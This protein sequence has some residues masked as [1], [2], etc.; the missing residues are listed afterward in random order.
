[1]HDRVRHCL[2][3]VALLL[4]SALIVAQSGP[5]RYVYDEL[6][7]LITVIDQNGDAA[8]YQYDAVGNL[9]S[10]TRTSAGSVAIFE[11][12]PNAGPVGSS[13][14]LYGIGFSATPTQ[15]T[16]TINGTG[17][18]VTSASTTSLVVTVPS[19]T[20]SG[21]IAVTS[22]NGSDTS[23]DSFTVTVS[24]APTISSFTPSSGVA[25][26]SISI[27]GTN[28]EIVAPANVTRFNSSFTTPSAATTT[29][30]TA[31]VP[32]NTGSGR[33]EIKTPAGTVV[34]I[35]DLIIPPAPYVVADV[36][37][38]TR[39]SV[40]TASTVT[41]SAANKIGLR[42]FDG[43]QGGRMS[44][45]GTNGMSGQ[46]LGCDVP[47]SFLSPFADALAPATCMESSGF[48]DTKT[49]ATSGTYSI[50][51]DPAGAA[52]GSVTLTLYD[53]PADYSNTITAGGSAVTASMPTPGQN[54][55]LTFSGT[56][57]DRISLK[58]TSGLSGYILGCD[59]N[60]KI[61]KPDTSVLAADTCMESSGFIDLQTL[62]ATGTYTIV[63]D[64]VNHAVGNLTLTLYTVP[65]DTTGTVS[66][67][68]S[69][70]TV[71]LSTPGQNGTLTFSGTATQQV[72]VR[73]TGNT[74]GST[75]VKLMKPDG[76]QLA[77]VTSSSQTFNVATQTL[78]TTGTYTI[79]IDPGSTNTGSVNVTVTNP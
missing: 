58:G 1:M 31:A 2:V 27:S 15:N 63:V 59:V 5:I 66:V 17:A 8:T 22:P 37:T 74:F 61:L 14:I 50:L 44:L 35:D 12:T 9:T 56:T 16:V 51:I 3:I 73:M 71:T 10:I 64:P 67:G 36:A 70:S 11:F 21:T 76:T 18:T 42:L 77:T 13:V 38:A 32:A 33:I 52:T 49:L 6:G 24:N 34:S 60:V 4:S 78:P 75:T 29:A 20:T 62:P 43:S 46:V 57:G 48:I 23:D 25:G 26:T 54:G 30:V 40:A 68:G 45:L 53:V 39:I 72:T 19:G 47:V 69:A 41:L 55:A 7:R 28:F 79:V 65:A